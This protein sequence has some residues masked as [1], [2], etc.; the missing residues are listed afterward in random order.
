MKKMYLAIALLG[1][2]FATNAQTVKATKT[3][4]L[5]YGKKSA[6][7]AA[8][9]D[10]PAVE[11]SMKAEAVAT[12]KPVDAHE[13]HNHGTN[14][15]FTGIK[16]VVDA[17]KDIK[18]A[19][20]NLALVE[21]TYNFGKIPQNKPVTH[22]F[23]FANTGK[24]ELVLENVLASCGCTTPKWEKGPYKTGETANINVGFNAAGA[25]QFTKVVTITYNGTLSKQITITGEVY[26]APVTPAPEN[27]AVGQLKGL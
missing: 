25:G 19:E 11:T 6:S 9:Q 21:T 8:K 7:K 16:P 18:L 14:E 17:P 4:T 1:I 13:G 24:T 5:K 23:K 10:A 26:A 12:V 2:T 3:P 22:D 27:K 15:P 20:D